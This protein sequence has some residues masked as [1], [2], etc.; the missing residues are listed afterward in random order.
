MHYMV[1]CNNLSGVI[2][3][4]PEA[5]AGKRNRP[6]VGVLSGALV[7]LPWHGAP[8]TRHLTSTHW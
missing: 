8:H 2:F 1:L 4:C 7:A 5:Y 3:S 6:L